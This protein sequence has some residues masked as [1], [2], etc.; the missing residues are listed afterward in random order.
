[1]VALTTDNL[2]SITHHESDL[3]SADI[4]IPIEPLDFLA[5]ALSPSSRHSSTKLNHLKQQD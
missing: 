2:Y 5:K 1:M 4:F 3:Q